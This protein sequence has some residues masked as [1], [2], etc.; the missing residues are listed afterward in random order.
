MNKNSSMDAVRFAAYLIS[1]TNSIKLKHT[2]LFPIKH[3]ITKFLFVW[4]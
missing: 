1:K 2:E 4:L 3:F